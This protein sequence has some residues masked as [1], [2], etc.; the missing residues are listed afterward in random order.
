M[1]WMTPRCKRGCIPLTTSREHA[2]PDFVAIYRELK[3][4][5]ALEL[6]WQE[7]RQQHPRGWLRVLPL[8]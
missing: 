1:S 7:Y 8:L 2:L 3:Q 4:R 6:L 5:G